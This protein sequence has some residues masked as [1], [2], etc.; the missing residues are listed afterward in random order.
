MLERVR[1]IPFY[2]PSFEAMFTLINK[3]IIAVSLD[4][5]NKQQ[6]RRIF[7]WSS[8]FVHHPEVNENPVNTR[9][10]TNVGLLLAPPS[11]TLAQHQT[12]IGPTS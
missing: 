12:N 8:S 4:E 9:R 2:L 11:T 3:P 1:N 7:V 10:R 5:V 6:I